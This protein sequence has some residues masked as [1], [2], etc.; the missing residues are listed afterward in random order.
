M[1]FQNLQMAPLR[2]LDSVRQVWPVSTAWKI[3]SDFSSTKW[4]WWMANNALLKTSRRLESI[5]LY[6]RPGIR[7]I[8]THQGSRMQRTSYLMRGWLE[9]RGTTLKLSVCER[10][11]TLT[12]LLSPRIHK[13]L[14]FS[15][16]YKIR[17]ES[18]MMLTY[19]WPWK[20]TWGMG[21]SL[22]GFTGKSARNTL[23]KWKDQWERG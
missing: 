18:A 12:W 16:R 3:I 20:T 13:M 7:D 11:F 21:A 8:T 6:S 5:T 22:G 2:P 15:S 19:A 23:I 10:R 4:Y 9:S 14:L 1:A 17:S